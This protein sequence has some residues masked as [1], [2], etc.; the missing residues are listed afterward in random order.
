MEQIYSKVEEDTLLH[1]IH[2][3]SDLIDDRVD[4][5]PDDEFLQVASLKLSKGKTFRAHKHIYYKK[6][7]NITQESWVVI[8]GKVRAFLY[9]LDDTIIKETD[10]GPGDFTITY[11]GGHNYLIL[12]EDTL[13]YEFKTGPYFGIE[14]DKV[15]IK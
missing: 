8:K 11:R 3:V 13:V 12:E 7:T 1:M 5:S 10:L 9:D 6:I 2:K 4:F 15:F 14:K